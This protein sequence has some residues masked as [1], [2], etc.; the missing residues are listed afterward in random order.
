MGDRVSINFYNPNKWEGTGEMS[1]TLFSHWGGM[2]FVREA[3]DYVEALKK[4]AVEK[5]SCMPLHRLDVQ[6]VMVD[7][8]RHIT[9]G[10]ERVDSNLYLGR[11]PD[12][13]DNSD[14]GHWTI[15]LV[16]GKANGL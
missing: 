9:K 16:T 5:G 10:E 15:D 12:E 11:D 3:K 14:N 13:G 8:I 6:T 4:E 1:V 7:F 2:D